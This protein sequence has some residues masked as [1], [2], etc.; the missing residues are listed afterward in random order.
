M[1]ISNEKLSKKMPLCNSTVAIVYHAYCPLVFLVEDDDKWKAPRK[2]V[3]IQ[4]GAKLV[5][6]DPRCGA[7]GLL[8]VRRSGARDGW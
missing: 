1:L 2:N 4:I 6:S 8:S 5:N 3:T 7:H